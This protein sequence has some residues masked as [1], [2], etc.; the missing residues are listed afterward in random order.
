MEDGLIRL[1]NHLNTEVLIWKK[2]VKDEENRKKDLMREFQN[3]EKEIKHSETKV[4]SLLT[5][6]NILVDENKSL[7]DRL[8]SY[9]LSLELSKKQWEHLKQQ[10]AFKAERQRSDV[11]GWL[12]NLNKLKKDLE[13][14]KDR[15]LQIF[16]KLNLNT[17]PEPSKLLEIIKEETEKLKI[18]RDASSRDQNEWIK[19]QRKLVSCWAIYRFSKVF[20]KSYDAEN[21]ENPQ[22]RLENNKMDIEL[23]SCFQSDQNIEKQMSVDRENSDKEK[24]IQTSENQETVF[25]KDEWVGVSSSVK[26]G[27][28]SAEN[29][30]IK[31]PCQEDS[32]AKTQSLENS[33][34]LSNFLKPSLKMNEN[35]KIR[36]K[37]SEAQSTIDMSTSEYSKSNTPEAKSDFRFNFTEDEKTDIGKNCSERQYSYKIPKGKTTQGNLN[38]RSG[39][40]YES[41]RYEE[42]R[43]KQALERQSSPHF[44]ESPMKIAKKQKGGRFDFTNLI[45]TCSP[46]QRN[47]VDNDI[48]SNQLSTSDIDLTIKLCEKISS[49]FTPKSSRTPLESKLTSPTTNPT[50]KT[51]SL[52]FNSKAEDMDTAFNFLDQRLPKNDITVENNKSLFDFSDTPAEK[53]TNDEFHFTFQD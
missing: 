25:K 42:L 52:D 34:T 45:K 46:M 15:S 32:N 33:G 14:T 28:Q 26:P 5:Q 51:E 37:Y 27:L 10:I 8:S 31:I 3:L 47:V 21:K 29:D 19:T 39:D 36:G 40:K 43:N 38:G 13:L 48:T 35:Y 2:K 41:P 23:L 49:P 24:E 16:S 22:T 1:I 20:H 7:I 17:I 9:K 50:E 18:L 12:V 30:V 44:S 4:Q 53:K 6:K 11:E